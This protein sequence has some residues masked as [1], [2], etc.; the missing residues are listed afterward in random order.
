ML[1]D[2]DAKIKLYIVMPYMHG[3]SDCDGGDKIYFE[4][5]HKSYVRVHFRKD[6]AEKTLLEMA[7]KDPENTYIIAETICFTAPH[8]IINE[9]KIVDTVNW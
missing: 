2:H 4:W 6:E 3:M 9:Y 8:S 7:K 5:P 1:I